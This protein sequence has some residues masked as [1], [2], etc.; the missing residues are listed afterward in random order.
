MKNDKIIKKLLKIAPD[1]FGNSK[2]L[3][4][5]LYGSIAVDQSHPFS[6]LDISIYAPQIPLR[7]SLDLEMALALAID[8]KLKGS[9]LSDVRIMNTLPLVLAGK[10]ITEGTLI[11]CRDDNARIE[12]ETSIRSAYFDFLPV[13]RNY[14]RTYL[15]QIV[16]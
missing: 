6:D 15:E 11:Y 5:Y 10:I 12:Y 2:V 7:E 9:P 14:Q 16:L 8:R 4:A 1:V 13:I 3:F